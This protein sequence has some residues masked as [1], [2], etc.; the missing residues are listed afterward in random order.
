M[1]SL[2]VGT[3]AVETPAGSR[4]AVARRRR[5]AT[6]QLVALTDAFILTV[7]LLAAYAIRFG[8]LGVDGISVTTVEGLVVLALP[9]VWLFFLQRFGCYRP[10]YLNATADAFRRYVAGVL[11]GVVAAGF[12]SFALELNLSRGFIGLIALS[13]LLL[14]GLQRMVLRRRLIGRLSVGGDLRQSTLLV[15]LDDEALQLVDAVRQAPKSGYEIV[16]CLLDVDAS[17]G[18]RRRSDLPVLGTVDDLDDVL[19]GHDIGLVLVAPTAVAAGT[20]DALM[21][22]LE[23]SEVGVAVA[24][25]LFQVVTRRVAIE[26]VANVPILHVDQVRLDRWK[27]FQ[28]RTLDVVVAVGALV[29]LSPLMLA[30][31]VAIKR[32]SP[33]PV[34]FSQER[35]GKD[36]RR[37]QMLKFRSMV[38]DA[39]TQLGQIVHL[40]EA[41]GHFFKM[42]EDPRVTRVGR[43]IR[44]WSIDELPQL[45]NVLRGDMSLV[46]PRPPVPSEVAEYES[47]H[48]RRLRTRPGLTGVWQTSGRSEVAFDEAVRMDIFYIEN[49]SFGYD[50]FLLLKTVPTVLRREGA[51]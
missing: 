47:W 25:S 32:D 2:Q 20:L 11:A 46:G 29:V 3:G 34:L 10:E 51:Y 45:V 36:G 14:G 41:E 31:L 22:R 5:Q 40:N 27:S 39:E 12:L 24:P 17:T 48:H 37:F 21:A 43:V 13:A 15:G 16:G 4:R 44:K 38:A 7:S 6:A 50:L 23:S 42:K 35:V 30:V 1:S 26:S 19:A 8:F 18:A 33:G 49:W 9:G 28:K